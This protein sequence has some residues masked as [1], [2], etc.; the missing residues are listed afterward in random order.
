[1]LLQDSIYLELFLFSK[2]NVKSSKIILQLSFAFDLLV[3]RDCCNIIKSRLSFKFRRLYFQIWWL[4]LNIWRRFGQFGRC[5]TRMW[6]RGRNLKVWSKIV[7]IFISNFWIF[8]QELLLVD[9]D[10]VVNKVKPVWEMTDW[11]FEKMMQ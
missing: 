3:Y 7:W 1:M 6:G 9:V 2:L 10:V 4:W 5:Q 8:F 11:I